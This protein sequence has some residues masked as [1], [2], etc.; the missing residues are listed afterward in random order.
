MRGSLSQRSPG[1]WR[2]RFDGPGIS[3]GRKQVSETVRGTRK[4]AERALRER[5]AAHDRGL[6]APIQKETT[7]QFIARWLD[8]HVVQTTRPRTRQFYAHVNRLYIEPIIGHMPIQKLTP[9]DVQQVIAGVLDK[10]LSP[11]TARR[12]YATLHRALVCAM[13]W[14]VVYRNVCD[15]I[16]APREAD[17]QADPPNKSTLKALLDV[18]Q[19]TAYGAAIWLLSYTGARR[20]EI[21]GIKRDGLNLEAGTLSIAGAVGREGGKLVFDIPKSSYSRRLVHLDDQTVSVLKSHL[22]RQA[23][24]RLK[25]GPAYEDQGFVFA[26]PTGSL[27]DPDKLTKAWSRIRGK[28]GVSCRLH[29]LRH[30]HATTL[31]EAGVHIKAVQVRLGHSSPSFTMATYAHISPQMDKDAAEAYAKA[32][33]E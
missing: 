20:G 30:A 23:E 2:L 18:A 1:T 31:I 32:M 28:V 33:Q 14:G 4:E 9:A 6:S 13:K 3:G 10:G 26:S 27:L 7:A 12:A 29:D 21:C 15:A 17:Y 25:L 5:L 16:D 24:W 22:A 8:D 11:T 19:E